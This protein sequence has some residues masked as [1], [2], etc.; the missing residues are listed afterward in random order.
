MSNTTSFNSLQ[1]GLSSWII[2]DGNYE[3][4]ITDEKRLFALEFNSQGDLEYI[5]PDY[6]TRFSLTSIGGPLYKCVGKVEHVDKDW[7]VMDVGIQ[8]YREE[9]PPPFI[10]VG[11]WLQGEIYIGID[12]F[13]YSERLSRLPKAPPLSY[14]WNIAKIEMQIAP[15]IEKQPKVRIR[16]PEKAGWKVISKTDAWKDD[17]GHAEYLLTCRLL[18]PVARQWLR[19]DLV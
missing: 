5:K 18:E 15:F 17:G 4:F 8:V 19:R 1:V 13:F 2:Q 11:I 7:W 9:K 6:Q 14:D 10:K 3:D 16:D 12:P